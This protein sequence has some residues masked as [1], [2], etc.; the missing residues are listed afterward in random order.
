M[1]SQWLGKVVIFILVG[2][3]CL[4][5]VGCGNAKV[6]AATEEE[7]T[8]QPTGFWFQKDN[9]NNSMTVESNGTLSYNGQTAN[10]KMTGEGQ[11]NVDMGNGEETWTF[12]R[13]GIDL[14]IT[15]PNASVPVEFTMQ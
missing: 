13:D 15:F 10:W 8:T 14:I 2:A 9:P 4:N 7:F 1:F 5:A 12:K 11:M 6:Q 3:L